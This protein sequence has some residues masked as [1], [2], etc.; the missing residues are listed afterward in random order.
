MT[1][2]EIGY[3][4][5]EEPRW[6]GAEEILSVRYRQKVDLLFSGLPEVEMTL[7]LYT[8]EA[9]TPQQEQKM[10]FY[11]DGTRYLT[12]Y[13][14]DCVRTGNRYRLTLRPRTEF[15]QTKFLGA[16]H[17]AAPLDGV[18]TALLGEQKPDY[19]ETLLDPTLTGYL[20]PASRAQTLEQIAFALGTIPVMDRDGRMWLSSPLQEAPMELAPQRLSL[21]P[22]V[23][24]LP[25]YTRFELAAHRYS[26]GQYEKTL[27]HES[28]DP[29]EFFTFSNP[30]WYYVSAT[31]EGGQVLDYGS[32]WVQ[33]QR[34]GLL[35]LYAKPWLCQ[36]QYHTLEGQ[37]SWDPLYSRVLTVRDKTLIHPEN[38]QA[39][40]Q[41]LKDLGQLRRQVKLRYLAQDLSQA[42][43]AGQPVRLP[44]L[45]GVVTGEE[46]SVTKDRVHL[47]LTIMC[48][49]E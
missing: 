23:R 12:G 20:P 8:K 43:R 32:N 13:I 38:V 9:F 15:L 31:E 33:I 24:L 16:V 29:A 17:E 7:E 22:Q 10:E 36:T 2:T 26:R 18:L 41:N 6:F 28:E 49:E 1:L 3:Y 45:F 47:D 4:A 27:I 44:G 34:Y 25:H 35:T 30:H 42:P 5:A 46:L 48:K 19:N 21:Q 14:M 40:L 11:Y 37:P 39:R